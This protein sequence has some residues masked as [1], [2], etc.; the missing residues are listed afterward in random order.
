MAEAEETK[1]LKGKERKEVK[2]IRGLKGRECIHTRQ[3]AK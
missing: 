2:M 3:R 1:G